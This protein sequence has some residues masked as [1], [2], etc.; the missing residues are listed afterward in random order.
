MSEVV[1]DLVRR[2]GYRLQGHLFNRPALLASLA[3]W[4]QRQGAAIACSLREVDEVFRRESEFS[5]AAHAGNLVAGDFVIGMESGPAHARERATAAFPLS[6]ANFG[7]LA[8][9]EARQRI[10]QL[11][12]QSGNG[13]DLVNDY[14]VFVAWAGLRSVFDGASLREIEGSQPRVDRDTALR[15]L[16]FE[17]RHVGGHLVVGGTAPR[18]VQLR[19]GACAAALNE[20][21]ARA[22]PAIRGFWGLRCPHAAAT[23]ARQATGLMWVGHPAMVQAG[24]FVF[25][26]LRAREDVYAQLRRQVQHMGDAAYD[27][28]QL[29]DEVRGHVLECLRHRPPFPL[30]TRLLPLDAELELGGDGLARRIAAGK[31][32]YLVLAAALRSAR[33]RPQGGYSH[34]EALRT[35]KSGARGEGPDALPIFGAGERSCIARD[36]VL[37]TLVSALIGLLQLPELAYADGRWQ[38]IV[39][40][41]PIIIRM[42]L[43]ARAQAPR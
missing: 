36:Q 15:T 31:S 34:R 37:D 17:L 24:A 7:P 22:L 11:R 10:A 42:R 6:L 3:G 18:W 40:D 20:R 38:C 32:V 41:G 8:A 2:F 28:A 9:Q 35:W 26:E 23:A 25:Q 30:L 19:A 29:R 27:D 1:A 43:K 16:F 33:G 14:L 13:F 39:H 4:G 21:V 12:G 5:S